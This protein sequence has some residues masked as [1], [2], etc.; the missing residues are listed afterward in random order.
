MTALVAGCGDGTLSHGDFVKKADAVCTAY[1]GATAGVKP[2]RTYN[3]VVAYVRKTLPVYESA[4]RRLEALKPPSRDADAVRRWLAADR[5]I[6]K[7]MRDLAV[8]GE[9]RDYPAIN[10]AL[11]KIDLASSAARDASLGLGLHVCTRL[12]TAR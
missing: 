5:R 11:A 10:V 1:R 8:A 4:L 3:G 2:P 9:R 6:V 7:A 12:V